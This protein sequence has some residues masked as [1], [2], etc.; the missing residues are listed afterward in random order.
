V[1]DSSL[2]VLGCFS[3]LVY[4]WHSFT[5][6]HPLLPSHTISKSDALRCASRIWAN[7]LLHLTYSSR[8]NRENKTPDE[9]CEEGMS[10]SGTGRKGEQT[11]QRGGNGRLTLTERQRRFF[12]GVARSLV[13]CWRD[14]V[15]NGTWRKRPYAPVRWPYVVLKLGIL[16]RSPASD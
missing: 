4:T 14:R 2:K 13:V 12:F 1:P 3:G 16:P 10:G 8:G 15:P 11:G 9:F 5:N 7:A 6:C